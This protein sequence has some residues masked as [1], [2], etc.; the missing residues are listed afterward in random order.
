M[1]LVWTDWVMMGAVIIG[2]LAIGLVLYDYLNNDSIFDKDSKSVKAGILVGMGF[3]ALV[4]V[5]LHLM[6]RKGNKVNPEYDPES[7]GT[8]L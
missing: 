5:G 4:L 1:N 8:Q 6:K 7:Y 3:F 2:A